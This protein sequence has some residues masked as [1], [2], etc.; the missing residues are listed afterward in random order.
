MKEEIKELIEKTEQLKDYRKITSKINKEIKELTKKIQEW[1]EENDK[2]S[3]VY[4]DNEI[5]LVEKQINL[6]FKTENIAEKLEEELKA[7][8]EECKKIAESIVKNK[9]FMTKKVLKVKSK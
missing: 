4:K 5:S 7:P 1:M 6:S 8:T 3:V 9:K 2:E